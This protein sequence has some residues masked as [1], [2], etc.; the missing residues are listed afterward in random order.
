MKKV[1]IIIIS[2]I[3]I[4]GL[5]IVEGNDDVLVNKIK[6]IIKSDKPNYEEAI[7]LSNKIKNET[8]RNAYSD[9]VYWKWST[10]LSEK[11]KYKKSIYLLSNVN[12]ETYKNAYSDQVYLKWV[13]YL[14]KE[15][16]KDKNKMKEIA[17]KIQNEDTRK[18]M[19]ERIK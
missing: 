18:A 3:F 11:D 19:L 13:N 14:K 6:E 2:S 10:F 12:N 9:Q 16:S 17:S 15:G 8:Y 1:I 4:I 7:S 5:G